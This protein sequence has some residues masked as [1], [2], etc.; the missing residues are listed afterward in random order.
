MLLHVLGIVCGL[1]VVA[2][3]AVEPG[4]ARSAIMFCAGLIGASVVIGPSRVPD[5]VWAGALATAGACIALA[6]PRFGWAALLCGGI[7]AAVWVSVLSAQGLPPPAA[8]V[9]VVGLAA[10]SSG[11]AALRPRFATVALREEAFVLVGV[12][13]V[14][15]AVSP[16]IVSGWESAEALRAAPLAPPA[17]GSAAWAFGLAAGAALLGVLHSLWRRR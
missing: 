6:T 11:L 9:L 3:A 7:T 1:A 10:A 8:Y 14:M 17:V 12:L 16:A 2:F 13:A 4:R 5:P 15:L